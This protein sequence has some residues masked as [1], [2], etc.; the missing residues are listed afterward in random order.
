MRRVL[1]LVGLVG[2]GGGDPTGLTAKS[3]VAADV[4]GVYDLS[5]DRVFRYGLPGC[6]FNGVEGTD[7]VTIGPFATLDLQ[8]DSSFGVA[9]ERYRHC[10]TSQGDSPLWWDTLRAVGTFTTRGAL[11][12]SIAFIYPITTDLLGI[13]L[14]DEVAEPTVDR[15]RLTVDEHHFPPYEMEF[16]RR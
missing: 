1:L 4:V 6:F 10:Y 2:C 13:A 5:T 15:I 8:A 14:R 11:L 16:T 3:S 9:W 12:D 7:S